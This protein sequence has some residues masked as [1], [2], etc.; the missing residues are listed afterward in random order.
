MRRA[1]LPTLA[2]LAAALGLALAGLGATA[3]P[4]AADPQPMG[5][6]TTTSGAVLAVDFSHWGGPIYRA[7]GTTPTTG[8]ELLNQG[9]WRTVGTGHDGPAFICR[10]GFSGYR[11]GKQ[12][13]P[14]SEE[15]CV[16][17]PPA[18][19]YWS[20]WH[21][22]PG[23]NDWEYSQ[24]GAMLYRP[25]P[26]SVDLW[27]F[28]GTDIGGTEGRPKVTPDQLR[29]HNTR[30]TGAGS[31]ASTE[32][33]PDLP[34][35]ADTGPAPERGATQENTPSRTHSKTPKASRPP[36]SMKPEPELEPETSESP[37]PSPSDTPS[38]DAPA[39]QAKT[40][41]LDA[42]PTADAPHDSGSVLPVVAGAALVMLIGGAAFYAARRRRHE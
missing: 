19:A 18:S 20:Y 38:A 29:A 3:A 36:E 17:T 12:F 24:L 22:D 31:P 11:S 1:V 6:C 40:P 41:V 34:P 13:P 2:R 28:G 9:G 25:K 4:A 33:A 32:K 10:I 15:D 37:S 39:A 7:C 23:A 5:R 26:G 16:L 35:D 27:I 42:E 21:A 14:T 30:P 8:Y